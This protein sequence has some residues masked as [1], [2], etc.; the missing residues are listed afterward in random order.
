MVLLVSAGFTACEQEVCYS[1][2]NMA[3][4]SG[5]YLMAVAGFHLLVGACGSWYL[6]EICRGFKQSVFTRSSPSAQGES[7]HVQ[8]RDH[9]KGL[10]G[11]GRSRSG[12]SAE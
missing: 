5:I 1:H 7:I 12:N 4:D 2:G 10:G 8:T 3:C 9:F 6:L 11:T